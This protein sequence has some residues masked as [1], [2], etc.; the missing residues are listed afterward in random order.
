MDAGSTPTRVLRRLMISPTRSRRPTSCNPYNPSRDGRESRQRGR[1]AAGRVPGHVIGRALLPVHPATGRRL[2]EKGCVDLAV[3]Q[4][5]VPLLTALRIRRLPLRLP[6]RAFS[7]TLSRAERWLSSFSCPSS[8]SLPHTP[9]SYAD[10]HPEQKDEC[11]H[12]NDD[13]AGAASAGMDSRRQARVRVCVGFGGRGPWCALWA[14][15]RRCAAD[16]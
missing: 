13:R 4:S 10:S 7:E 2:V 5:H 12:F 11:A 9:T 3:D 1:N 8:T 6:K 15:V 14:V 16:C